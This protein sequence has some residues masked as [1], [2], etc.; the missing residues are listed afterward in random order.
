MVIIVGLNVVSEEDESFR[1]A[2]AFG[3]AMR[4]AREMHQQPR[5]QSYYMRTVYLYKEYNNNMA[6]GPN[7]ILIA[8][9]GPQIKGMHNLFHQAR[10]AHK[11]QQQRPIISPGCAW[12][13]G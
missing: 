7:L 3:A 8:A 5:P 4:G 11:L 6:N 1:V 12:Y 2:V 13:S 10:H 9:N